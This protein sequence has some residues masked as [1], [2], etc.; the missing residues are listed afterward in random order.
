VRETAFSSL[1]RT[2]RIWPSWLVQNWS[3]FM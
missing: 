1:G 2:V 3:C